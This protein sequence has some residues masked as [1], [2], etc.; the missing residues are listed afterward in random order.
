MTNHVRLRLAQKGITEAAVVFVCN[1]YTSH[2][3]DP[4]NRSYELSGWVEGGHLEVCVTEETF[5]SVDPVLKT[6]YWLKRE[7]L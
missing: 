7:E 1:A 2:N 6:A 4:D 5:D 3:Y